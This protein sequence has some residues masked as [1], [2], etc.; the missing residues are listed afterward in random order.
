M[1]FTGHHPKAQTHV[2]TVSTKAPADAIIVK[3]AQLLFNGEF[4]RTGTDLVITRDDRELVLADYFKG[5]KR[6]LASPDGAY[7]TGKTID[8]LTGHVQ[9]AQA[10]GSAAAAKIIGHVT[11]LTGS[12]TVIRNGVS[13]ILNN[14]DNVHQGDV[15]QSGSNSTVGITFIDGS[16]FGLA[17]NARMVLNEM[18]YDPNGSGNSS[19]LSLVQG[20]ISFVAGATAKHGDMKVDTPV[21]TMGIR[22]T[23][24]LVEIDFEVTVPGTAPPARFQV[25]VEPD[26]TTGS[27]VLLDRVT[28]APIAT[29]N[30]PGTVTT[31]SGAGAVSFLASAQLSPELMKLI[32]EVFSQKFTDNS[33]PKSDTHFTDTVI[34][35]ITFPVQLAG[36][37]TATA[38]VRVI[39]AS[40]GASGPSVLQPKAPDRIPGPPGVATFNKELAERPAITGSSLI[41]T[42]SGPVSYTDIN[43]GDVPTVSTAFSQFAYANAA[44]LNMTATLTTAQL[45]AIAAVSVPLTVVQDP[46]ARNN[47]T[48]TWTYN[49]EDHAL[50]FLAQG[51]KLTLTYMARV[52][53]NFAPANEFSF[54]SF[55]ITITGTN[56]TPT[57][58]SPAQTAAIEELDGEIDSG[59][60]DTATGTIEFEDVDLTDEHEVSITG[61]TASGT[62]S[63]LPGAA[64]P[65]STVLNWLSL[66]T[67]I[68][69]TDGVTG[70][71]VWTFSAEDHYFDYLA[72]GET[73]ALT[74]T[75]EVEDN[76][77]ATVTQDV[78]VTVT[79]TNDAPELAI[80]T[81]G[82]GGLHAITEQPGV[83]NASPAAS[84]DDTAS[85]SLTFRDVDLSDTHS[86]SASVPDF[87]WTNSYSQTLTASQVNGLTAASTLALTL[88]DSTGTGNGSIDFTYSAKDYYFDFLAAGETLTITYE[89][90]VADAHGVTSTQPVTITVTGSN[91][92]P[93][94]VEDVGGGIVEAGHDA[95]NAQVQGNAT[96]TGNVLTNDTD[97]DLTDIHTVVGVAAGASTP[98]SGNVGN[99][100][101]GTYGWLT[102]NANG[103]WTYTLDDLD[104][105]TDALAQ[106]EQAS[107]VFS[108]TQSDGHGGTSTTTLTINITGT[109]DQPVANEPAPAVPDVNEGPPV[110]EAG[111]SSGNVPVS[112]LATANGNVLTNDYDVDD[113]DTKTVQSVTNGT[114]NSE[115]TGQGTQ[116]AGTYGTLTI[117]ADGSW[118]YALD[119]DSPATQALA[120]GDSTADV[121][122]YTMHD[123]L[124]STSSATLS[125]A[126]TGTNDAPVIDAG[127]N[128][129]LTTQEDAPLAI[130]GL[131]YS[132]V[133]GGGSV[134]Q[135]QLKVDHGSLT[136]GSIAGLSGDLDGSDGTLLLEGTAAAINAALASGVTYLAAE[137]Y[138]GS[139][140]LQLEAADENAATASLNIGIDVAPVADPPTIGFNLSTPVGGSEITV[141]ARTSGNQS[142]PQVTMLADGRLLFTW[143]S[144]DPAV[145]GN[146]TGISARVG[147]VDGSG[148]ITFA[149]EFTVNQMASP[150]QDSPQ[151]IQLADGRVLFVWQ[152]DVTNAFNVHHAFAYRVGTVDS[153][154]NVSFSPEGYVYADGMPTAYPNVTQTADGHVV[155]TWTYYD[156]NFPADGSQ[157]WARAATIDANGQA[158][159]GTIEY[160][161]Q[162]NG[163]YQA[164]HDQIE[165]RVLSLAD[166]RIAVVWVDY[167]TA[168]PEVA[169]RIGALNGNGG[170]TFG[171]TSVVQERA[172]SADATPAITQLADGRVLVTWTSVDPTA[173]GSSS[174]VAGRVG[175]IDAGGN[176]VWSPEFTVNAR[177]V[178]D[179]GTPQVVTLSD[180]SV[181]FMWRSSDPAV[182]GDQAGISAR[183][184]T[185]GSDGQP[186]W[187][188]EF[189]VDLH[190]ALDQGFPHAEQLPDGRLLFTWQSDDP[191]AGGNG[192]GVVARIFDMPSEHYEDS[193]ISLPISISL[194]DADGS[195]NITA[196]SLSGL[197]AGFI[198]TDGS[199]SVTSSGAAVDIT[200]W[201]LQSLS[202]TPAANWN[203][204]FTVTVSATVVDSATFSDSSA[205]SDTVTVSQSLTFDVVAVNDAPVAADDALSSVAEDSG[206]RI[207]SFASLLG[208]DSK[209]PANESG[210]SLTITA[211]S[212][213]VGGT[214]V[215]NGSNIEFTP[216]ANF[217][218]AASFDYTVQDNGQTDGADDFKTDTGSVTFAVTAVNDAPVFSGENLAATYQ[219][220]GGP[221]AIVSDVV[222]T[223]IDSA[224]YAN[225]TLTATVTASGQQGD[226]VSIASSQ[227]IWLDGTTVMYDA[228]GS[229]NP[230]AIGTLSNNGINSLTFSLNGSADDAAVAKLTQAIQFSNSLAVPAAG[231]RT[232]TFTLH[233]GG[234]TAGGGQ[235]TAT[236]D[237]TVAVAPG[238]NEFIVNTTTANAQTYSAVGAL[239]DGGFVIAW[240]SAGQDG[241][242]TGIYAQRYD[243]SGAAVG[244][245]FRVNATTID[246]QSSPF[247]QGLANGGY[248]IAWVTG[249]N[250]GATIHAQQ[251]DSSGT[252]I[253]GELDVGTGEN[254]SIAALTNGGYVITYTTA[255][256]DLSGTYALIYDA[257]GNAA[258]GGPFLVNTTTTGQQQ[259]ASVVGTADGGFVVSW[260]SSGQDNVDGSWGVV[261]Q[262]FDASGN[263]LGG[264]VVANVTTAG[265]QYGG[266]LAV[267]TDGS[268]VVTW[269]DQPTGT[270]VARHFNASGQAISG[271]VTI[272]TG[273]DDTVQALPDGSY[274]VT[275]MAS[276]G[277]GSLG[278]FGQCVTASDTLNGGAFQINQTTAGDQSFLSDRSNPTAVLSSG[279]IVSTWYGAPNVDGTEIYARL[280][281]VLQAFADTAATSE[282]TPITLSSLT[283]NDTTV[284]GSP[285][286]IVS[287]YNAQNG[288]VALNNGVPIFTPDP[289]FSGQASFSYWISETANPTPPGTFDDAVNYAMGDF[290]QAVT[291]ADING[292]GK[293][294][295][296]VSNY[297]TSTI[298]FRYGNGDG[299]FESSLH[300][301]TA[302]TNPST[303]IVVADFNNDGRL[304]LAVGNFGSNNISIFHGNGTGGYNAAIN[305]AVAAG[306]PANHGPEGLSAADLNGD[307]NVDL[308]VS[309]Y[310]AGTVAVTLN[311]GPSINGNSTFQVPVEYA[312]GSLPY[313]SALADLDGD[314]NLDIV[315]SNAGGSVGTKISV[316]LGNGDGTFDAAT[317]Y[318]TPAGANDVAIGDVNGDGILDI[319]S[320]NGTVSVFLGNGDGTFQ[321]QTSYAAGDRTKGIALA[322]FNQDGLL[323]IVVGNSRDGLIVS[324]QTN[325]VSILFN[326]G[327]GIFGAPVSY[328]TGWDTYHVAVADL[329]GDGRPDIVAPNEIGGDVSVLLNASPG[330]ALSSATVTVNVIPD[331]VINTD[332]FTVTENVQTTTVSGLYVT[333]AATAT[334]YTMTVETREA[335]SSVTLPDDAGSLSEI[336]SALATGVTYDPGSPNEPDTDMVTLTVTDNL[337]HSDIVNFIFNEA[338]TGPVTLTGTPEKDVIFATGYDDVLTGGAKADQFV[339]TPEDF[340]SEDIITDFTLGEDRID[341]RA[342][343]NLDTSNIEAWLTSSGNVV[344]QGANT[345]ITLDDDTAVTLTNVSA[346]S[347]SASNFIVSQYMVGG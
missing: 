334:N 6:A 38:M 151:A 190:G 316:L 232:V 47:G 89:V 273:T 66:G 135:L 218:G 220:S 28:L 288:T 19:F 17:S 73:V 295:M 256:A 113:P 237:V 332:E 51:E 214:A 41:D 270:I 167:G 199:H 234:G 300:G 268:F 130:S 58:A 155:F 85:G 67:F 61:V 162:S 238:A 325:S 36:G 314:G 1:P 324:Q 43:P 222:A 212:N 312:V 182:D 235:D 217:N 55:T 64:L 195:E 211:V 18:V 152:T 175:A 110:V 221:V 62:V 24:V 260:H 140:T 49:V 333:T 311:N 180:G 275:Y 79:G 94:A 166:G 77:G 280:F 301:L 129:A 118:T 276:D 203:G 125:I 335:A 87:N 250:N 86:V 124:G 164:D 264:E 318:A 48:A 298:A 46:T 278:L 68:D 53:N 29:V 37:E 309:N 279:A 183:I 294:D 179:Q 156:P 126:I 12:A 274:F 187:G 239:E 206:V 161:G 169:F 287:V 21:A 247:V 210:Q 95:N 106:G 23:A 255:D 227:F 117:F 160:V 272:G 138:S 188:Q 63:G 242:G 84:T 328:A 248:V 315:V 60:P 109:N 171:S 39:A 337:G 76:Y 26:G 320:S 34:P 313:L 299:T 83:T 322:D 249:N 71:Q 230:V 252:A 240:V 114:T 213:V 330:G 91:D 308:V 101:E 226:T 340:A 92:V 283:A 329:N 2:D 219:A 16:V 104:P 225:G 262:R 207:I 261:F 154:G 4:K 341:L 74:Y 345:V 191:A 302:G 174:A 200:G 286:Q 336:S 139:D 32:S 231:E 57:I 54:A 121:F 205:E 20:T 224:N 243:S 31:V 158:S 150:T 146:G 263:T 292:D 97:V 265:H 181:L 192:S 291:L 303:P 69:S 8:A 293:L 178:S 133:D 186:A 184:A 241:D 284:G 9:V 13:I 338:G 45:A 198:L 228:D 304:D 25:L 3:D 159:F 88:H 108:Y 52:D 296:L 289:G 257:N 194:N 7:L 10:D 209:G 282:D 196:R 56:D 115:V 285:P 42:T 153:S 177:G 307:G 65:N 197:P 254:P 201:S 148:Q 216:A 202:V 277:A 327:N 236:F 90:T 172:A 271:E 157:L 168:D 5:E 137:N 123:T 215:I 70:S 145:D 267:L 119:N 96:T 144:G 107:D 331:L 116:I 233:D 112:G 346:A 176:V 142:A 134:E 163:S 102:L 321:P 208:N 35:Q 344:Q 306:D 33:N 136:L 40:E 15:V 258:P 223:D 229:G 98:L 173:D 75:V 319:V 281:T 50:D 323:D 269:Q 149:N 245:E 342:F 105:E 185:I 14:G 305:Y 290:P 100:I 251:Y 326:T 165:G 93:V 141:D 127:G 30:Q 131:G 82:A 44:G 59:T 72:E 122:T 266:K 99:T 343:A 204:T 132:D 128:S 147:T 103:T 22:G 11:K 347:L 111:V 246:D 81:S 297:T 259:P 170:I 193:P 80:D 317:H 189:T 339:F 143:Q 78:V 27:Y 253:G 310:T 244:S 120:E